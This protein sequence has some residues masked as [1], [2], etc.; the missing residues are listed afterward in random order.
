MILGSVNIPFTTAFSPEGALFPCPAVNVL[1]NHGKKVIVV[2][3]SSRGRHANNVSFA[4]RRISILQLDKKICLEGMLS[5]NV[6]ANWFW[7]AFC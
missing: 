3:G 1:S 2:I 6:Y 4:H 7:E 5:G